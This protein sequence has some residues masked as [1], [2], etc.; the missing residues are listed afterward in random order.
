MEW[1]LQ[2]AQQGIEDAQRGDEDAAQKASRTLLEAEA[3]LTAVEDETAWPELDAN[4]SRVLAF[5]ASWV[6]RHGTPQEQRLLKEA[7][8]AVES[9][10]AQRRPIELERQ[11][12]IVHQ[13]ADAAFYRQPEAWRYSFEGAASRIDEAT[14][15]S[16][17][18]RLV[19][20]GR[21]ALRNGDREQL[22]DITVALWELLPHTA[23]TRG[24]GYGS[25]LR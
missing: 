1:L 14:D 4:A 6:E 16:E 17:A 19:E 15:I 22:R 20:R 2:D 13:L 23:E 3:Q 25:G 18:Q 12:R 9:A 5:A 8:T 11:L 7:S 21:Q 24:L 10:R